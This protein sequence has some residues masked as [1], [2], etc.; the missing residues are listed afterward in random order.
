MAMKPR[1]NKALTMEVNLDLWKPKTEL[2]HKVKSGEITD[3]DN[4]LDSGVKILEPEIVDKLVSGLSLDLLEVGQSKGKFGG[5]KASIWKQTQKKTCEGSRINFMAFAVVGNRDGYV[6]VGYGG[7]QETV[8]AR[9][10]AIRNAKLNIIKIKRACGSWACDC[11]QPHSI[12]FKVVGKSGSVVFTIIPA[13][14]GT[15]LKSEKKCARIL[16]LAGLKDVYSKVRGQ[17]S[18]KLNL[19]KACFAALKQLSTM[20]MKPEFIIEAGVVEGS[21][22]K[23]KTE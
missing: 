5:G 6:G 14:K 18:T 20:K 21:L 17:S 3:I 22:K 13:P 16:A 8:P 4:L 12:P 11:K 7:G 23:E 9:E 15:N 19:F 2:G 1:P 10:K